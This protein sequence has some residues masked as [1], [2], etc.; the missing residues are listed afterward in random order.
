MGRCDIASGLPETSLSQ[1]GKC[2]QWNNKGNWFLIRRNTWRNQYHKGKEPLTKSICVV[3]SQHVSMSI[4][5]LWVSLKSRNFFPEFSDLF[6][7]FFFSFSLVRRNF[8][9]KTTE[10]F[11]LQFLIYKYNLQVLRESFYG[12]L[13]KWVL[14]FFS[15]REVGASLS[16]I[17]ES[18]LDTREVKSCSLLVR[19]ISLN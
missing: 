3:C 2:S 6:C 18:D 16:F 10:I 11:A 4:S 13:C 14:L 15:K 19:V 8:S 12:W 9:L 17:F 5:A 1:Q 7:I